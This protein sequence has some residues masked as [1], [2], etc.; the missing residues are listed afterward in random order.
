M[1]I[2]I[3]WLTKESEVS[4]LKRLN[5]GEDAKLNTEIDKNKPHLTKQ[6]QFPV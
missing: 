5:K 2:P 4:Q 6:K 1:N 3:K